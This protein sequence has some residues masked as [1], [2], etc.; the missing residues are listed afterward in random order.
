MKLIARPLSIWILSALLGAIAVP[1]FAANQTF[2]L[3]PNHTQV[4]FNWSHF[5][6]SNPGATFDISK[7]TLIWDEKDPTQSSVTVTIPV[8][9]VDTQVPAL[10]ARFKSEFFNV[11]KYPTITFKSTSVNRI[12]LSNHYRVHGKLTVHGITK[13]VTLRATLNKIG[14]QPMLHAPAIGFD[15]TATIKRSQFGL[16]AYIPVVSDLVRIHITAEGVAAAALAKEENAI[17]AEA[18]SK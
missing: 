4:H 12:G 13:P 1:A 6:F 16:S 18:N 3:D 5:G 2:A 9:S 10:D 7:G 11:D 14:E 15:A 8:A 17:K